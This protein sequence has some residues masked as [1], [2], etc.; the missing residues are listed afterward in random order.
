MNAPWPRVIGLAGIV[1]VIPAVVAGVVFALESDWV[2]DPDNP[3]AVT[4]YVSTV[5]IISVLLVLAASIL[6][7]ALVRR[8]PRQARDGAARVLGLATA[9]LPEHRRDWGAAMLAELDHIQD[10]AAR[11]RFA[12]S[13]A[14]TAV[15]A[16]GDPRLDTRANGVAAAIGSAGV[17]AAAASVGWFVVNH[18]SG[19]GAMPLTLVTMSVAIL[20]SGWLVLFPP[21]QLR[22]Q[23]LA[24]WTGIGAGLF[25]AAGVFLAART[26]GNADGPGFTAVPLMLL[27]LLLA[28]AAVGVLRRSLWPG[29]QT[30]VWCVVSGV[31]A[32]VAVY[33][34]ESMAYYDRY[35]MAFLDNAAVPINDTLSSAVSWI[36]VFTA[37]VA[38]PLG[39]IAAA[40]GAAM[41]RGVARLRVVAAHGGRSRR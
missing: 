38:L 21:Q 33:V 30:A 36:V 10:P 39:I 27:A 17:A 14:R 28:P 9:A 3:E 24:R 5:S 29:V 19:A 41:G 12:V 4:T 11:R 8:A 22:G 16:P 1:L 31:P 37:V 32:V 20:V 25:T 2:T 15:F 6:W 7:L 23:T 40:T 35:G 26:L 18:P 13:A 34:P